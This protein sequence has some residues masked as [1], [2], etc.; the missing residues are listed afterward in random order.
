MG[1][2]NCVI[3][4]EGATALLIIASLFAP[5]IAM[6]TILPLLGIMLN[7]TSSVLYGTDPNLVPRGDASRAFA[8]LYTAVLGSGGI[9]PIAWRHCGP[10][11]S[12]YRHLCR[13]RDC[14]TNH[15]L[16][17]GP[18]WSHRGGAFRL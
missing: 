10:H 17:D 1:V 6:L 7:G 18:A 12:N 13:R 9:A 8:L 3:V 14:C 16:G 4:T 11:Q 2:V 5:L 15:S